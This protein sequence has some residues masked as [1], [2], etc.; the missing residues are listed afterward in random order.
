MN[1]RENVKEVNF[2]N[3]ISVF[4]LIVYVT[5]GSIGLL[6]IF[7]LFNFEN[8]VTTHR[9]AYSI[10]FFAMSYC[11]GFILHYVGI[12]IYKYLPHKNYI[13]T[14]LIKDKTCMSDYFDECQQI[15]KDECG[16]TEHEPEKYSNLLYY[17][18]RYC[19]AEK[20]SW[21]NFA[22]YANIYHYFAL[23]LLSLTLIQIPLTTYKIICTCSCFCANWYIFYLLISIAFSIFFMKIAEHFE[24]VHVR[25]VVNTYLNMDKNKE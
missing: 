18:M 9:L 13:R 1:W 21:D 4:E 23:S 7:I 3:V 20:Y 5:V 11:L 6:F 17:K 2:V 15:A 16:N 8:I 24:K 10:T 25:R 19:V 22:E 12:I 14:L